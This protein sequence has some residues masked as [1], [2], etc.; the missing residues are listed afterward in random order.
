MTVK[1]TG[2]GGS[3]LF[4]VRLDIDGAHHANSRVDGLNVGQSTEVRF[5]WD[6]KE[7]AHKFTA[8]ADSDGAIA[9]T[10]ED[11]NT[12]SVDYDAT[13]LADLVVD[14][15][16]VSVSPD[17]PTAGDEVT[18]GLRVVNRS[19]VSSGR[20]VV[21][22]YRGGSNQPIS[23]E[24]IGSI[25]GRNESSYVRFKWTA[26]QGSHSFRVVVD[27]DNDVVESDEGNN[28]VGPFPINVSAPPQS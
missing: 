8:T 3:E 12:L 19:M 20:F 22:L 10:S 21:S 26:V 23:S 9:E 13:E 27:S 4:M 11:N 7:G 5:R 6:A 1:N 16:V 25:D 2:Q 14:G 24:S 17:N 15:R 28:Q 18:I